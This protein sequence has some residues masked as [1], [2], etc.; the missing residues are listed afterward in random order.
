MRAI[1]GFSDHKL[2]GREKAPDSVA[3]RV[4]QSLPKWHLSQRL[5]AATGTAQR[6]PATSRKC[7]CVGQITTVADTWRLYENHPS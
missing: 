2:L 4:S 6:N 7:F 5:T 3:H 1:A